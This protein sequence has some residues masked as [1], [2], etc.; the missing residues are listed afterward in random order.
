MA[1]GL[2]RCP[3]TSPGLLVDFCP[4]LMVKLK[5]SKMKA[6][7]KSLIW[8]WC[9]FILYIFLDGYYIGICISRIVWIFVFI[10]VRGG[11]WV[12][13]LQ[14][15]S[16]GDYTLGIFSPAH[17]SIHH[18]YQGLYLFYRCW[19]LY[20]FFYWFHGY[21]LFRGISSFFTQILSIETEWNFPSIL[22]IMAIVWVGQQS[23]C[24]I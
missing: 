9:I 12:V 11:G 1:L 18:R 4:I 6:N 15:L 2:F 10:L 3:D 5:A 24:W 22:R 20:D 7:P 13:F 19:L 23:Q 14:G 21:S 17:G 16:R 8:L